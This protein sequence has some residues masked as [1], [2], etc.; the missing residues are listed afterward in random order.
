MNNI[1]KNSGFVTLM[2]VLIVGAVGVA[3][4]I[5]FLTKGIDSN[6]RVI[7]IESA[8]QARF[9]AD[10]CVELALQSIRNNTAYVG[11]GKSSYENGSCEYEVTINDSTR[12]NID[13]IGTSNNLTKKVRVL[14]EG[15]NPQIIVLSWKEIE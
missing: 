2:A 4:A 7:T 11:T 14:I 13:A 6:K 15:I 12:R 8:Y 1:N 10:E 3:V 5:G 9:Y